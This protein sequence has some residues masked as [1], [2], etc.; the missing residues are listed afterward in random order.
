MLDS[1]PVMQLLL[2]HAEA[3]QLGERYH[4]E[5]VH[6]TP[7][8]HIKLDNF[9][10]ADVLDSVLRDLQSLP[11]AENAFDRSQER[12]KY[13]YNPDTLPEH[14]RNL[15][16]FFNSRPF[17]SFLEKLT[18]IDGL[19]VDPMFLGG[20]IHEVKTGGHLD[21]HADFNKHPMLK[22][23]RR[24]NVL[25]YLNKDWKPEYGGQFEIWDKGMTARAKSFDPIFNRCVVFNTDSTSFH[26]NPNPVAHEAGKSRFSI[27]L[28][29]YTA[30]WDGTRRDH[31]TQFKVRPQTQDR[32][33][34]KIRRMEIIKDLTPPFVFHLTADGLLRSLLPPV[35]IRHI[36]K[37]LVAMGWKKR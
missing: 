27:A 4:E 31:T 18:G 34:W 37:L 14:T 26:G 2:N 35:I 20:G 22:V 36:K 10:D 21:I 29:Y 8:P 11:Q 13:S 33:D 25:I 9:L 1:E 16:R 24:I 3:A 17:V 12:K 6:G 32:F 5:Y 23:E 15:F 7:Y 30:T 28:Y 19:I